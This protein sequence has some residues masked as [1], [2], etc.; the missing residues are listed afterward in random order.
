MDTLSAF[1][2]LS[3]REFVA[4]FEACSFPPGDFHHAGHVRLAR[5]YLRALGEAGAQQKMVDGITRL[6]VH[7][8]APRKFH[9]T[10]TVAWLRL[11]SAAVTRD[12]S[13]IAFGEWIKGFPELTDKGLLSLHYSR[14]RF[15][16][17]EAR[18]SWMEP[19]L[20]PLA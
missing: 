10:A 4:A 2:H 14:E 17:E 13:A 16:S 6:A 11:V 12:S 15:D 19:D 18:V 9:Y 7:A 20:R 5:I 1:L 8:G 3:D